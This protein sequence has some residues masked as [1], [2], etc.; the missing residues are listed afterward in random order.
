MSAVAITGVGAVTSLGVGAAPLLAR[1]CAGESGLADG[2]GRCADF[3]PRVWLS[4]KGARRLDRFA[5][6]AVVAAEEAL[7]DAGCADGPPCESQR[8]GCVIGTGIGG[9]A[10]FE[11]QLDAFRAGGAAAVSPLAV[12]RL[13]ANAA[14]AAVA[15]RHGLRGLSTATASACASGAE[16]IAAGVRAIRTG[17]LDA[18]VVGGAEA[19]T[20]GFVRSAFAALGAVSPSD[21]CRPFDA[22]RDGFVLGEGA[23]ALVLEPESAARARGARVLGTLRGVGASSDAFHVTA[24]DPEGGP[25]AH[26]ISAALADAGVEPAE[27]AYVNAHG[28]GTQLNDRAET[29]ALERAL[30]ACAAR[31]PV[32]SAKS[33][34]GHSLGAAGAVEAVATLLALRDGV[35]PPTLGYGAV[36][37][38]LELDYVP[39]GPRPLRTNGAGPIGLSNSFGFGGHNV[40]LVLQAGTAEDDR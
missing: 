33:A 27:L 37:A 9:A 40:V 14:S 3:D 31:V 2:L 22:R 6:L 32:S 34:I 29:R 11:D 17:E 12:P 20:S 23:A 13:M 10:T 15:M 19:A 16:A 24:P 30:G 1:W 26:A 39:D 28:T 4:A 25:A 21:C 7:A 5:Q 8:A 38:G 18:V 36:E 35:A